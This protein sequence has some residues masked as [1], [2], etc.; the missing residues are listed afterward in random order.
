MEIQEF[1]KELPN[2]EYVTDNEVTLPMYARL[3]K[4]QIEYISD[5]IVECYEKVLRWIDRE[6]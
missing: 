2:T 6:G 5:K 3:E 4:E 1:S